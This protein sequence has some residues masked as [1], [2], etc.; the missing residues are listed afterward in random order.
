MF[1]GERA[2]L[3]YHLAQGQKINLATHIFDFVK[4]LATSVDS[5][6]QH[7]IMFSCLISGIYLE[8][9]V[10]LLLFAKVD[11]PDVPLNYKTTDN[12]EARMRARE[13]RAQRASAVQPDVEVDPIPPA[14]QPA[15]AAKPNIGI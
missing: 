11:T 4:E 9:G 7:T 3:L 6:F 1:T 5:N 10:P 14:P 2:L 8:T 15:L 13:I 12:L